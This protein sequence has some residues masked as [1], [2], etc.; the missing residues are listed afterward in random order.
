MD[1][2]RFLDLYMAETQEHLRLLNR[3]LLALEGGAGNEA[4]EEAFRAAHTIKG[5]SATMGYRA[6]TDLAHALEEQLD[7]IRRGEQLP[8]AALIDSLLEQADALERSVAAAVVTQ[9]GSETAETAIDIATVVPMEGDDADAAMSPQASQ[10]SV[11][12]RSVTARADAYV[13]QGTELIASVT[14]RQGAP[15]LAA[16]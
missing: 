1:L 8:E 7:P 14:L 11:S 15:I 5:M 3:S 10:S 16:R 2:N 6:V 12:S 9:S 4:I 13:P